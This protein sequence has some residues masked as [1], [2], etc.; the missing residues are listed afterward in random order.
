MKNLDGKKIFVSGAAAGMGLCVAKLAA[1]AGAEVYATDVSPDGLKALQKHDVKISTLDVTK[2]KDVQRYFANQPD[3]DGI[4]NMAGWVHH[5]N[6]L[7]ADENEWRKSFLINLISIS[8]V[9]VNK[10]I[11]VF[12]PENEKLKFSSL[13]SGKG[14]LKES[15]SPFLAIFSISFPPG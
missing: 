14:K 5:G 10:F 7:Q 12:I 3:F 13:T 1:L 9:F 11:A 6:I 2:P 8:L 15:S 4:V